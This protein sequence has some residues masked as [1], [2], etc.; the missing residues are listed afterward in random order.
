MLDT[1]TNTN[2]DINE[3]GFIDKVAELIAVPAKINFL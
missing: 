2:N 3:N 1:N